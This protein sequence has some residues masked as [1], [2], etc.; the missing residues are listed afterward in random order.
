M[1]SSKLAA[2]MVSDC[3]GTEE[4]DSA[5]S[6]TPCLVC[7]TI[8]EDRIKSSHPPPGQPSLTIS[9]LVQVE[10]E[11]AH[12]GLCYQKS[13]HRVLTDRDF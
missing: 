12:P 3:S 10:P 1:R 6:P 7:Q 13:F 8:G 4:I 9:R 11:E 5:S 2:T